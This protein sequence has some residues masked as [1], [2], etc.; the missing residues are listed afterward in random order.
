MRVR[1]S[2][3]ELWRKASYD[4][5]THTA[6]C[7][8]GRMRCAVEDTLASATRS[9]IRRLRRDGQLAITQQSDHPVAQISPLEQHE[10]DHRQHEPRGA[11]RTDDWTEPREARETR[12]LLRGDDDGPRGRS[13]GHLRFPK[14]GLDVFNRVLQL[15]D[16]S[17]LA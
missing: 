3:N 17:P 4:F 1:L 12:D 6:C 14:V 15:L 5:S 16:G 2:P 10:D 11:Q 13:S 9:F 8:R 7:K